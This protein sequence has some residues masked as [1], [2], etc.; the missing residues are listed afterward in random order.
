MDAVDAIAAAEHEGFPARS[1]V[2]LDLERMEKMPAAMREYYR[3]WARRLLAD[4]RYR[5]GVYVHA[6]NAQTVYDDVKVEFVAAGVEE[7]PRV[8]VATGRGFEEG[9]APQDVGFA[10]AGMALLLA[11]VGIYGVLSYTVTQRTGEIGVRM[12]LGASRGSVVRLVV[13]QG[14]GVA[15]AGIAIGTLGAFGL[16]RA[17]ASLLDGLSGRDPLIFGG[18]AMLLTGVAAAAAYVPARRASRIEPVL[19][20]RYE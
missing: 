8:W 7:E 11:A 10:F 20:L 3:A 14:L 1:I 9:K 13:S 19:A 6:H 2:F 5:P 16:A 17:L 18:A 4:G 12:A 15:L